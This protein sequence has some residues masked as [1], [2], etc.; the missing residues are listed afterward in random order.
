MKKIIFI[1]F[2]L[3]S[4]ANKSFSQEDLR[5][6]LQIFE[7]SLSNLNY[8]QLDYEIENIKNSNNNYDYYGLDTYNTLNEIS[9]FILALKTKPN[10]EIEIKPFIE[11]KILLI[12]P[13][14]NNLTGDS[15]IIYNSFINLVNYK[16]TIEIC[17]EYENF[18]SKNY[19]DQSKVINLL[20]IITNVKYSTFAASAKRSFTVRENCANSCMQETFSNFNPIQWAEFT[21][22]FLG[23]SLFW[24]YGSCWYEC[25]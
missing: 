14:D 25:W 4:I 24:A 17:K 18:I 11:K 2:A 22:G 15:K 9:D 8:N 16:N 1:L 6:K 13:Y 10:Y 7:K 19:K 21:I 23:G 20:K 3:L 5:N 12:K